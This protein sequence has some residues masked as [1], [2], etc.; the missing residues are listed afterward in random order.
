VGLTGETFEQV[1]ASCEATA[2][3]RGAGKF[4]REVIFARSDT[5]EAKTETEEVY[6]LFFFG[7]FFSLASFAFFLF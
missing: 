5:V 7:I 6:I 3:A 2:R 4:V 1:L